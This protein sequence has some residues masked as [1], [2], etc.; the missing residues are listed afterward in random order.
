VDDISLHDSSIWISR[1]KQ[2]IP[3]AYRQHPQTFAL[4][5]AYLPTRDAG[6]ALCLPEH[7]ASWRRDLAVLPLLTLRDGSERTG[8]RRHVHIFRHSIASIS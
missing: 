7:E 2:G 8:G 1:V 5:R 6:A 4:L 3:G